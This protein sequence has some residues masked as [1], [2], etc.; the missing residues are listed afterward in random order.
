MGT[1]VP[2][3]T[4]RYNCPRDV[5]TQI[6]IFSGWG[7]SSL[8]CRWAS[9]QVVTPPQCP[10]TSPVF[11]RTLGSGRGFFQIFLY[12]WQSGQWDL[13][14]PPP[15]QL[16]KHNQN[17]PLVV[18]TSLVDDAHLTSYTFFQKKKNNFS[19]FT[20]KTRPCRWL[21]LSMPLLSLFKTRGHSSSPCRS[22]VFNPFSAA[23]WD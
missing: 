14:N 3:R 22:P 17:P 1:I 12:S 4:Y 16:L 6:S 2:L 7:P 8:L 13:G 20:P 18:N 15:R 10:K 23:P 5:F 11:S 19:C 9:P 21:P